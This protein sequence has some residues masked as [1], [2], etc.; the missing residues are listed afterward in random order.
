M[1][2]GAITAL[3]TPMQEG[4]DVDWAALEELIDWQVDSGID[5]LV[6]AGTTG[7][8][9]TLTGSEW[10]MLIK[11]S[12]S[13]VA[14]RVPVIAGTGS[15]ATARTVEKTERAAELGAD[16][17]LVVTPYYNR[18]TQDGLAAHFRAV[19][20]TGLP[21]VLYNVPGR[22]G[23][24]LLPATVAE[25]A[26]EPGVVAIKEAVADAG[27]VQ[28]LVQMAGDRLAVLSGDDASAAG[29]MELGAKGVVSVVS[30][31]L[32]GAMASLCAES[33]KAARRRCD[34]ALQAVYAASMI[35]SNPIPIKWSLN[36]MGIIEN[37]LRLPLLPLSPSSAEK[38]AAVIDQAMED[39]G[40]PA[41]R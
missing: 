12:V 18:P 27:R 40:V 35:E 10:E 14:G 19:A 5:G 20:A 21:V 17:A 6:I 25:L 22:T 28:A 11:R 13:K 39:A 7:E 32:P 1:L 31:L 16:A 33:E 26:D 24:D 3:V 41:R 15:A 36:R 37:V 8:S 38:I 29:S 4:G 30:N 23:V 9:A 34:Q 2:S